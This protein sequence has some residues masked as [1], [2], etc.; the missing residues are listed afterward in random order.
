[1]IHSLLTAVLKFKHGHE[2][3]G[4][5]VRL[6]MSEPTVQ[7]KAGNSLAKQSW[8]RDDDDGNSACRKCI[9]SIKPGMAKRNGPTR[10]FICP[11]SPRGDPLI[12]S[13]DLTK[14]LPQEDD[15]P[16]IKFRARAGRKGRKEWSEMSG[17]I[18]EWTERRTDGRRKT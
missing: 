17:L 4:T 1:M 5:I 8:S 6:A 13:P 7:L 15:L 18:Q 11:L 14:S 12:F 3:V 16:F 2:T 10:T 9:F